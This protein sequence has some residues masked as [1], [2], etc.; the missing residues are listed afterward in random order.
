VCI[1]KVLEIFLKIKKEGDTKQ[2]QK[3]KTT[4][5]KIEEANEKK[6]KNEKTNEEKKGGPKIAKEK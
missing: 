3:W 6:G 4:N 1:L 5:K 2:E